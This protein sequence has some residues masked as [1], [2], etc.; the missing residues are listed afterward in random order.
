MNKVTAERINEQTSTN[1]P[2]LFRNADIELKHILV[3]YKKRYKNTLFRNFSNNISIVIILIS[4]NTC[5][6]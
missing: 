6:Q 4:Y 1:F 3:N 2:I 5:V